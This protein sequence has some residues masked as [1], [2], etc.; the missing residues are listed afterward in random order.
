MEKSIHNITEADYPSN[1]RGSMWK[2]LEVT[3]LFIDFSRAYDSIYRR[4]TEQILLA[5]DLPK[6]MKLY[7]TTKSIVRSSDG[8]TDF[9]DIVAGV[10]QEGTLAP[11]IL[12]ICLDYQFECQ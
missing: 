5:F 7:K 8:D 6:E 12:I 3:Q 4:K 11:Y 10:L 1:D 2:N 9:F